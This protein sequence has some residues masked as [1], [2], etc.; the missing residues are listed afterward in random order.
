VT[1]SAS[2]VVSLGIFVSVGVAFLSV[3]PLL[4]LMLIPLG[5]EVKKYFP[6][7]TSEVRAKSDPVNSDSKKSGHA[8]FDLL[9]SHL[10]LLGMIVLP[11]LIWLAYLLLT[12]TLRDA[13]FQIYTFNRAYYADYFPAE[14]DPLLTAFATVKLYF[15]TMVSQI[16]SGSALIPALIRTI[17]TVMSV[18]GLFMLKRKIP[19][20]WFVFICL[21]LTLIFTG[22]R[23]YSDQHSTVYQCMSIFLSV[24]AML[25]GAGGATWNR[26]GLSRNHSG[27]SPGRWGKTIK[28]AACV[29]LIVCFF[30]G[31]RLYIPAAA[32][33]LHAERDIPGGGVFAPEYREDINNYIE[34]ITAEEDPVWVISYAYPSI[35]H[36]TNRRWAASLYAVSPWFY[37]GFHERLLAEIDESKP[38]VIVF[39]PYESVW[40]HT[41][42]D[43]L[44]RFKEY[45]ENNYTR[46]PNLRE[47]YV[48]K[49]Y[50]DDAVVRLTGSGVAAEGAFYPIVYAVDR[51]NS[52]YPGPLVSGIAYAQTFTVDSC[53]VSAVNLY[54]GTYDRTNHSNITVSI[55]DVGKGA[56]LYRVTQRV[57]DFKDNAYNTIR[58]DRE[59]ALSGDTAYR[60]EFTSDAADAENAIAL[61][62]SGSY[63]ENAYATIGGQEQQGGLVF[64]L[65][66]GKDLK[67]YGN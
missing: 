39:D 5:L 6:V 2:V 23:G 33:S 36:D 29:L 7:R 67:A 13:V 21:F 63:D 10:L 26:P 59:I 48:L 9:K 15:T 47:M 37:D 57:A 43:A 19:F 41:Y 16:F 44:P 24:Y 18:L 53:T 42:A 38:K 65:V 20:N 40:G 12:N 8:K 28:I 55:V 30:Y 61:L 64:E 22:I 49:D 66:S 50:Y 31:L 4:L 46:F 25:S 52:F 27:L 34:T 1:V 58:F 14:L 51:A 17:I 56:E 45:I 60:I 35:Y 3:Y 62:L 54:T 32:Q 11:F